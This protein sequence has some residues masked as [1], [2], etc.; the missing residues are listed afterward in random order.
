MD[1]PITIYGHWRPHKQRSLPAHRNPG[2]EVVVV[3]RGRFTWQVEGIAESIG[4]G[5][6][7]FTLP[8]QEHGAPGG[9]M[10]GCALSYVV[11]PLADGRTRSVKSLRFHPSLRLGLTRREEQEIFTALVAGR[12]HA[13]PAASRL[14]TTLPVLVD[15]LAGDATD[16]RLMIATLATQV[17]AELARALR[18][19][20][21]IPQGLAPDQ[22]VH[23][24][25][26]D[27]ALH[28]DQ[29]WTLAG[30]A[31]RCGL[32]RTRFAALVERETGD[33]PITFVLRMRVQRM[34]ELLR[35]GRSVT[36]SAVA[37]GFSS[38]QYAARVFRAFTGRAPRDL[39]RS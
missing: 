29:P 26:R 23:D 2:L 4:P 37:S 24:L 6:A 39:M 35:A 10:P 12:Q 17:V 21:E 13:I 15:E 22:R 25:L 3:T 38:S 34:Q 32:G 20:A 31:R 27:L 28:C 16:K 36:A 14:L 30:M 11:L 7:F 8:W 9:T 33:S 1:Q 5:M 18:A 19:A